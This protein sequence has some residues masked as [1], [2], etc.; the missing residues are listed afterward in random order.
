MLSL[1]FHCKQ[2]EETTVAALLHQ[3]LPE[4]GRQPGGNHLEDSDSFPS[5]HNG[6]IPHHQ[7]QRS[8]QKH[9]SDADCFL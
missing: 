8:V 9:Q 6:S 2:N 3:I 5:R 1:D 4:T 7:D